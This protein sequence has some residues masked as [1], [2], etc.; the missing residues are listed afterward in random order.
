MLRERYRQDFY[1]P[2]YFQI[3]SKRVTIATRLYFL[4]KD[5]HFYVYSKTG[6]D[7]CFHFEAIGERCA[8]GENV[9][10]SSWKNFCSECERSIDR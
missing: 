9:S 5:N 10:R 6:F 8:N 7:T 2:F 1:I 3:N 4:S